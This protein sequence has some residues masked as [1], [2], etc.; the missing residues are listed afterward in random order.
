MCRSVLWLAGLFAVGCHQT[1]VAKKSLV[2]PP[3][4]GMPAAPALA[5]ASLEVAT[6]VDSLG[7]QILAANPQLGLSDPKTGAVVQFTTI[8]GD[9][10]TNP[11]AA[12][13]FHRGMNLVFITEGLVNQCGTDAQLAAVLCNELG[14]MVAEKEVRSG[15]AADHTPP[16]EVPFRDVVGAGFTADQTHQAELARYD[17]ERKR[18]RPGAGPP[19]PRL[20]AQ[21]F[22]TKAGYAATDLAAVGPLLQAAEANTTFQKQLAGTP[23]APTWQ[24]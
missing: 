3:V 12:E 19:D 9:R 18:R 24:R 21:T 11:N 22:L 17:Q 10:G 23:A 14:K 6:R 2:P 16:A 20:L 4:P 8:G 1:D 13:V 15:A 7:R 5:P